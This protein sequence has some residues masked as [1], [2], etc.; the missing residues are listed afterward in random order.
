MTVRLSVS[1]SF[2]FFSLISTSQVKGSEG[3]K[4][5]REE[6]RR[7]RRGMKR[8]VLAHFQEHLPPLP[9]F[10]G[11]GPNSPTALIH[12]SCSSFFYSSH[13]SSRPPS[14]NTPPL[15]LSHLLLTPPLL[16]SF[17]SSFSSSSTVTSTQCFVSLIPEERGCLGKK[18]REGKRMESEGGEDGRKGRNRGQEGGKRSLCIIHFLTRLL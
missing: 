10:P 18:G 1:S 8:R 7:E 5:G 11:S 9:P 3:R 16:L 12:S 14:T 17:F 13:S 2:S 4:K 6:G 15:T